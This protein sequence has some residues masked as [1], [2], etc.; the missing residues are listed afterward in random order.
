MGL[1]RSRMVKLADD[2]AESRAAWAR[3]TCC[4]RKGDFPA[5]AM[6]YERALKLAE[7]VFG[8]EHQNTLAILFVSRVDQ[9]RVLAQCTVD[10][11]QCPSRGPLCRSSLLLGRFHLDGRVSPLLG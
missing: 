1:E 6:A 3:E 4:N 8:P 11:D 10:A 5:A 2:R 9:G 7:Q